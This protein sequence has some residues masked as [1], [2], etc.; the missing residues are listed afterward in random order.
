M[1]GG[2]L[3]KLKDIFFMP[4]CVFCQKILDDGYICEDCERSLPRLEGTFRGVEFAESCVAPLKYEGRVK[5]SLLRYKFMGRQTY[6]I[7]Y[8]S[9]IRE[10]LKKYLPWFWDEITWVPI[11]LPR[12]IKR[13]YDQSE[14]IARETAELCGK[15]AKRYLIKIRH[16]PKQSQMRGAAA[17]RANVAGAYRA[18]RKREL[19][20]KR[21]LLIDDIITT[22]ATASEC[23]KTLLMAGAERIYCAALAKAGGKEE[24]KVEK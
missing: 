10:S 14:L 8:A 20:G 21:I 16:T 6:S 17:R 9:L 23:A 5:E 22:G 12:R 4:K 1:S 7:E 15:E 3:K 18:V 2:L 24:G 13:K 19:K 11:S